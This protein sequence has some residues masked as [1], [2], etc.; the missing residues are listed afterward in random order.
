MEGADVLLIEPADDLEID[1]LAALFSDLQN[2]QLNALSAVLPHLWYEVHDEPGSV[3]VE[4]L[5]TELLLLVHADTTTASIRERWT[6]T[7]PRWVHDAVTLLTMDSAADRTLKALAA[8][9][10]VSPEHLARSFRRY[11]GCTMGDFLRRSRVLAAARALRDTSTP[12][13]G[14]ACRAGFADQSHLTRM[15]RRYM[16]MTPAAYRERFDSS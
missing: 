3:A 10:G 5:C 9:L 6:R 2:R 7:P 16:G 1:G 11:V 14:I 15:F 13:G 12:I 8:D 4:A